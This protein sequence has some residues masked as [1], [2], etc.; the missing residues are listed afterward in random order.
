MPSLY[1]TL[2]L[3]LNLGLVCSSLTFTTQ[4][5]NACSLRVFVFWMIIW[6]K[7]ANNFQTPTVQTKCC[8]DIALFL[9]IQ[10]GVACKSVGCL[11]KMRVI[12][13]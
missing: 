9:P 7:K 12:S 13:K 1:L 8:L 4:K 11:E 3:N 6:I 5:A 10:L 2:R